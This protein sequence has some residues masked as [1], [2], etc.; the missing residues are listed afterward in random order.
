MVTKESKK[1]QF[2][3]FFRH[4]SNFITF[5]LVEHVDQTGIFPKNVVVCQRNELKTENGK[6]QTAAEL[7]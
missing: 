2:F 7:W 1:L 3:P 6:R 5:I 4:K